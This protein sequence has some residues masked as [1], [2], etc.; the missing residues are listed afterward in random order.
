[1]VTGGKRFNDTTNSVESYDHE[2]NRWSY[3]PN[4]IK[5]R[6]FHNLVA[7]KNKLFAIGGE[8]NTCEVYDSRS[9]SFSL[10]ISPKKDF[11]FDF[12]NAN[13]AIPMGNKIVV[14]H[15]HT[16]LVASYDLNNERWSTESN[17]MEED[18]KFY[19]CFKLPRF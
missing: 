7:V 6:V 13:G 14:F 17:E 19:G 18:Y 1:M 3:M 15:L 11:E 2:S 5:R 10:M 4:M 12:K 8:E 9:K 16:T